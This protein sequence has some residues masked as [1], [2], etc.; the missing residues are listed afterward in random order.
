MVHPGL[1]GLGLIFEPSGQ[2]SSLDYV[3]MLHAYDI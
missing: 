1:S 2:R 3:S